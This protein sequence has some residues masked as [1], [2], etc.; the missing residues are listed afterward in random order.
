MKTLQELEADFG[1]FEPLDLEAMTPTWVETHHEF[2]EFLVG[3]VDRVEQHEFTIQCSARAMALIETTFEYEWMG[4]GEGGR[5]HIASCVIN[6]K[7]DFSLA[8]FSMTW[9]DRLLTKA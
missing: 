1:G 3:L 9:C 6:C 7:L 8:D 4:V 2:R 5:I